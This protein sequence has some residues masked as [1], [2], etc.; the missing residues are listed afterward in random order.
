LPA[1]TA[2]KGMCSYVVYLWAVLIIFPHLPSLAGR[3]LTC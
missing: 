2:A 1:H 3:V